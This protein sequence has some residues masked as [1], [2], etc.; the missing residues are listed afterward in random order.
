M[1]P[2]V[3]IVRWF[4]STCPWHQLKPSLGKWAARRMDPVVGPSVYAGVQGKF[5]MRLDLAEAFDRSVYLNYENATLVQLLR[6]LL[7]PGDA[8]VDGG[9][10]IGQLVLVASRA[11]GPQGR[12]YAFEPQLRALERLRENL[13]LNAVANVTLVPKGCW[14]TAGTSTLYDFA[15]GEID[16][17]SMG[18]RLDR[19]VAGETVI[20]T[21]RIDEVVPAPVR[22]IKLDVE[23]AEWAAL[24]GAERLL[25]AEEPPHLLLELNQKTS[26][27][28]GYQPMDLVDWILAR[29]PRRRLHLLKAN[30]KLTIDRDR[31][32]G[33]LAESATKN[34]NVWF[35]PVGS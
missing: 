9:A 5:L 28:F 1:R 21:V 19:E 14:D 4:N 13:A 34:R 11:V 6:R 17:P 7:R 33:L 8:Y 10:S 35:E 12:V 22:L 24:R 31:L 15:G 27:A 29:P 32:R 18:R 16:L 30:R 3:E 20:D 23:G 25:A 26:M 2:L